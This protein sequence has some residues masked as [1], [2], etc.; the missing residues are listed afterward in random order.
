MAEL[1][2]GA[3]NLARIPAQ[4][5]S[6]V[7]NELI[8]AALEMGITRFDHADIYGHGESERRFGEVLQSRPELKSVL[9]V[10]SKCGIRLPTENQVGY[11]DLSAAHI[12]RSVEESLQRLDLEQLDTLLLHRPDP[13]V[14]LAE[15]TSS[16]ADLL[17]SGKILNLGVSNMSAAQIAYLQNGL[18]IKVSCNQLELSLAKHDFVE[19][20]VLVNHPENTGISFPHG[21]IEYCQEN[22]VELQAWGAL[23]QGRY[24]GAVQNNYDDA[25]AQ[26]AALVYELS[27]E[28]GCTTEEI[29]LGWLLAHPANISPLIG[30]THVGRLK[31]CADS[32]RVG[33]QLTKTHWYELWVRSRGR[34]LP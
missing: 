26:T 33:A 29:V 31:A 13:L 19:S 22:Q 15:V 1:I 18:G 12:V 17:A 20:T 23:A 30:T 24:S 7:I 28:Y 11:Y 6:R 2:Y 21:T 34:N 27:Q 3:M 4:Q 8:D 5:A 16:L 32:L 10:Q 25:I 14:N 9:K